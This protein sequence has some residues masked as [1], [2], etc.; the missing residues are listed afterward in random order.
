MVSSTQKRHTFKP[1]NG[2][3]QMF[4]MQDDEIIVVG[5]AGT[6]KSRACLEKLHTL[7][8]IHPGAR[9]LIV[10][11]TATSLTSSA[12]VTWKKFVAK[13]SI[14]SGDVRYYGGSAEEAAQYR[15][16]NGSVV[17]L[18]G[19]DK[20]TRIMST[21][22]DFIFVQEATELVED[23]WESLT[24]RLRN[25]VIP[26]QQIVGDCNPGT[27]Y[28]WLRGRVQAG[29]AQ[30]IVSTHLDNPQ[31]FNDDGTETKAG[32]IYLRKLK[33]LT[34]VR[35]AR[36]FEG[37]WAAAEGAIYDD[38]EDNTHVIDSF[39]IP[40]EWT[41]FWTVD[42]GFTNPFVCQ[43][44][45]EDPD[46][47]LYM[48]REVY[49]TRRTV[50]E[51]CET[52][53]KDVMENLE[54]KRRG[55]PWVGTWTEPLPR[56]IFCDHDAEGRQSFETNIGFPTTAADKRVLDGIQ[57]MQTRFKEGRIFFFRDALVEVDPELQDRYKP[58]CTIQEVPGYVWDT[59]GGKKI[60]EAPVKEDDHGLDAGRYLVIDRDVAGRPKVRFM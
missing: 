6:G 50:E 55:E 53:A 49:R 35:R 12:L 57:A 25:W 19:M 18:G 16:A 11:K 1:R 40:D 5:P 24:T 3:A 21:E 60:K 28:H 23:D 39:K 26:F 42:F 41:R 14:E 44:W 9:G 31:L 4:E 33:R 7:M 2:L 46:G 15:Y 45:A 17:T 38:F 52:I 10:R 47:N 54:P 34:G 51:H 43:R 13:E 56:T 29:T 36:L 20:S 30:M 48:Y 37:K 27:P 22:Y 59:S 58:T 8:L 32:A